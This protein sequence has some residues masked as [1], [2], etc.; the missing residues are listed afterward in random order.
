MLFWFSIPEVLCISST[1]R[2]LP[3]SGFWVLWDPPLKGSAFI[4]LFII[5]GR[6]RYHST[7]NSP[8][9]YIPT[10]P[11]TWPVWLSGV[12]PP[13]VTMDSAFDAHRHDQWGTL[14]KSAPREC[15][16]IRHTG[17]IWYPLSRWW[18]FC[19][20]VQISAIMPYSSD[21]GIFVVDMKL[22]VLK[23]SCR[24]L[25]FQHLRLISFAFLSSRPLSLAQIT[26][27]DRASLFRCAVADFSTP[28]LTH[29][30][31][32][33]FRRRGSRFFTNNSSNTRRRYPRV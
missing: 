32:P 11:T 33:A 16:S 8:W 19:S 7:C 13:G 18:L 20:Y 30:R 21:V 6:W 4:L 28:D 29:S 10:V 9:L 31:T 17:E 15:I 23:H 14:S 22:V 24:K 3:K 5:I 27:T 1:R 12:I 26:C 2:L 25:Y